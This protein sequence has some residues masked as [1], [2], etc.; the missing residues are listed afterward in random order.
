MTSRD[1]YPGLKVWAGSGFGRDARECAE[2]LDEIDRLR[3]E[4][5]R[6]KRQIDDWRQRA[7]DAE[8]RARHLL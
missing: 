1:D 5:E 8:G 4:L 2:A 3:A 7:I 6:H